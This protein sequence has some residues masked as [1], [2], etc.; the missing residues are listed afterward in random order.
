[1]QTHH[2]TSVLIVYLTAAV[3][4]LATGLIRSPSLH[5]RGGSLQLTAPPPS[6]SSVL[7]MYSSDFDDVTDEAAETPGFQRV[8]SAVALV[9][10]TTVGAGILALASVSQVS[11]IC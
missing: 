4:M 9:S 8:A 5:Q 10:G 3:A 6:P 7:Y 11:Y 2:H 1:M